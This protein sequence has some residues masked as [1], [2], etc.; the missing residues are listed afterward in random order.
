MNKGTIK[1]T[2]VGNLRY[3]RTISLFLL[4]LLAALFMAPNLT[5]LQ[6]INCEIKSS[7]FLYLSVGHDSSPQRFMWNCWTVN[8]RVSTV[9]STALFVS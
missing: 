8:S 4:F 9:I 5:P 6:E 3:P 7:V 2:R 1:N